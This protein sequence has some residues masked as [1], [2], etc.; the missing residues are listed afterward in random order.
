[1]GMVLAVL[2]TRREAANGSPWVFPS[3]GAT[4][5][6][7]E[8]KKAWRR[9]I[10]RAGLVDVRPHDLRRSLG[11]W[12]AMTG[13][14]LPMVG[15]MLG[16]TQPVTTAIYARLAVDPVREAAEKAV[17]AMQR[18]AGLLIDVEPAEGGNDE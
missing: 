7:V 11:S 16:H 18:A 5:H 17:G 3:H 10:D 12:M 9:V 14:G 2:Q 13:A 6:L 8:P 1:M 15:K 4:G